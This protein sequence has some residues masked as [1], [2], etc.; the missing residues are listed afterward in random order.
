MHTIKCVNSWIHDCFGQDRPLLYDADY[1]KKPAWHAVAAVL[2][3]TSSSITGGSSNNSSAQQASDS[4][5]SSSGL[6]SALKG[7]FAKVKAQLR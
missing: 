2:A 6:R 4:S 1:R 3:N 5:S 7:G